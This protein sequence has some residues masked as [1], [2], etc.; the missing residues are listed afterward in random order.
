MGQPTVKEDPRAALAARTNQRLI[1]FGVVNLRLIDV[2]ILRR[3]H[4]SENDIKSNPVLMRAQER[5]EMTEEEKEFEEQAWREMR[6]FAPGLNPSFSGEE[7]C[8]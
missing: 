7:Y 1:K 2:Y 6:D 5:W 4:L 8:E 3:L